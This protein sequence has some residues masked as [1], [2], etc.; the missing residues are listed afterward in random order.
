MGLLYGYRAVT[1]IVTV[2]PSANSEYHCDQQLNH[3][4]SSAEVLHFNITVINYQIIVFLHWNSQW[5]KYF[6]L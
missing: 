2:L 1:M 3:T 4:I 5:H 6:K